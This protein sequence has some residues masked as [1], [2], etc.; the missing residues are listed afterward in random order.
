MPNVSVIV[1]VYNGERYIAS[2]LEGLIR[3]TIANELEIIVI[4]DGSSDDSQ[5][6]LEH[7]SSLYNNVS[8]YAT[9]N[10]GAAHAR[11]IGLQVAA[12]DYIGFVDCDDQVD[13]TMFEKLHSLAVKE[14]ADIA[15]CGYFRIDGGDEQRRDYVQRSCFGHDLMQAPSLLRRN[16]PYIWN[17]IFKRSFLQEND[18]RFD[19]DLGIYEDLLFTYKTFLKANK[20]VRVS[21]TLYTYT[22]TR[23]G[24]LTSE[25]SEKRMQLFPAFERLIRYY[26]ENNAFFHVQDELLSILL[27]H[28]YSAFENDMGARKRRKQI[29]LFFNKA[30]MFLD[31][32]FPWWRH[33]DTYFKQSK[34]AFVLYSKPWFI[35]L[36]LLRPRLLVEFGRDLRIFRK[37]CGVSRVGMKYAGWVHRCRI[38][39]KRVFIDSQRG[40]NL[41]GNM[42]YL[43]ARILTNPIYDDFMID[44]SCTKKTERAYRDLIRSHGL[45]ERRVSFVYHNSAQFAKALARDGF[46]FSDT[47][48][49]VYFVKR[50]N[51]IYLNTWHGTP[52]KRLGRDMETDYHIH[53]NLTKN[54]LIA[55]YLAY[56]SEYMDQ[57]MRHAFTYSGVA[58]NRTVF[59]GYPRNSVFFD[60]NKRASVRRDIGLDSNIEV[61]CYMPTW[62]G[63]LDC[64]EDRSTVI[65]DILSKIDAALDSSQRMFVNLHPYDRDSVDYARFRSIRPFPQGYETYEFLNACDTLITDYSSV[66]FDFASSRRKTILFAY[67]KEEYLK[68]R[69]LYLDFDSL[70][71]P[72]ASTVSELV[73]LL[74]NSVIEDMEEFCGKFCPKEGIESPDRLL[75][76]V[77]RGKEEPGVQIRTTG[78]SECSPSC[79]IIWDEFANSQMLE[80]WKECI[81]SLSH[82]A[83][84]VAVHYDSQFIRNKEILKE[85]NEKVQWMGVSYPYTNTVMRDRWELLKLDMRPSLFDKSPRLLDRIMSNEWLRAYGGS[86]RFDRVVVYA[87]ARL[88]DV[89]WASVS[90]GMRFLVV[91]PE[92]LERVESFP[93]WLSDRFLVV[94]VGIDEGTFGALPCIGCLYVKHFA[95]LVEILGVEATW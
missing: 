49:P 5:T 20:V 66:M 59:A 48:M 58:K 82:H 40:K 94:C 54:F 25:F 16:V 57:C 18:F 76:L 29:L 13:I 68:D 74:K 67:D 10:F 95:D 92:T 2:A 65:N 33:C 36:F 8:V 79:L 28:I 42:F 61:I 38:R 35:S 60:K 3:Q 46:V 72:I 51:Q 9:D 4:N 86:D 77:L 75:S 78:R 93:K 89:A 14:N 37:R 90:V 87:G 71:L 88:R 19:E 34:K 17:K 52:L 15:T 56:Q 64:V 22:F 69:G 50:D 55:D 81:N 6:I 44:L 43:L 47:S 7:Y 27:T 83:G 23:E 26:K 24:S 45:D 41:N 53:A 32:H 39:P 70:T 11:N 91:T 73:Y 1:P 12:G 30:V 85:L 63:I 80:D 31:E 62:R 21:E 84:C